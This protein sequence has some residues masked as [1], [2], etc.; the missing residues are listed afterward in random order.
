[1]NGK[2]GGQWAMS[3]GITLLCIH[4]DQMNQKGKLALESR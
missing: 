1:M 3:K 4:I 2:N